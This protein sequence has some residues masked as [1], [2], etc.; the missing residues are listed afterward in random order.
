MDPWT[1]NLIH[2]AFGLGIWNSK[3][4]QF[5]S[6]T[7]L[8]FRRSHRADPRL[9]QEFNIKQFRS[10]LA[11][12]STCIQ[13]ISCG[14][15]FISSKS[16]RFPVT[17]RRQIRSAHKT[18]LCILSKKMALIRN[19]W[20]KRRYNT[21]K[22]SNGIQPS[23]SCRRRKVEERSRRR[24]LP[25]LS[26]DTGKIITLRPRAGGLISALILWSAVLRVGVIWLIRNVW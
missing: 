13:T 16:H 10:A 6:H 25:V 7:E 21:N 24:P 23:F 26:I 2:Y 9:L 17:I 18:C 12:R 15:G 14:L 4:I 19:N 20:R 3:K 5:Q 8:R 22:W 11:D 1:G